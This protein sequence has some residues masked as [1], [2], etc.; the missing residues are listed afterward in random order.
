MHSHSA[1]LAASVRT[2]RSSSG[3][4][5][6]DAL[7]STRDIEDEL[8]DLSRAGAAGITGVAARRLRTDLTNEFVGPLNLSPGSHRNRHHWLLSSM[9]FQWT[10]ISLIVFNGITLGLEANNPE[11][12]DTW[13]VCDHFFT[14]AFFVEFVV[15]ASLL[16]RGYF[17]DVGNIMDCCLVAASAADVW[18]LTPL[19]TKSELETFSVLRILRILRLVR[20]FRIFTLVRRFVLI[21]RTLFDALLTT[22]W[23]GTIAAVWLYVIAIFTTTWI[24]HVDPNVYPGY[25]TDITEID[26]SEI[27][28]NFNPYTSFG[29]VSR[30]MFTLFNIA[31]GAEWAEVVRPVYEKQPVMAVVLVIFVILVV[32]GVLNIIIA[33]IVDTVMQNRMHLERLSE[34]RDMRK[35]FK[36]LEAVKALF[37]QADTDGDGKVDL[38]ELEA[39]LNCPEVKIL[40]GN[41]NVPDGLSAFELL[42]MLDDTGDGELEL[43]EIARGFYRLVNSDTFQ[44]TCLIHMGINRL[45]ASARR[46]MQAIETTQGMLSR[47]EGAISAFHE[48][49][50]QFVA[51]KIPVGGSTTACCAGDAELQAGPESNPRPAAR[52][53][54]SSFALG[55]VIIDRTGSKVGHEDSAGSRAAP[56]L[57]LERRIA[58]AMQKVQDLDRATARSLAACCSSV[59]VEELSSHMDVLTRELDEHI[60]RAADRILESVG[61]VRDEYDAALLAGDPLLQQ[62]RL[63]QPQPHPHSSCRPWTYPL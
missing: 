57:D 33:M 58:D 17:E 38:E 9:C 36:R 20:V 37:C 15:K 42:C 29:G 2:A 26:Q 22:V 32:Y 30:S 62:R 60:R 56:A 41:V 5:A 21:L 6:Q 35:K 43:N 47:L 55:D 28:Q 18:I 40:L 51:R 54:W 13:S 46:E 31:L 27:M 48:D 24:G 34:V 23:V 8:S 3:S 7:W 44:K 59:V 63:K 12:T 49:F 53:D 52:S 10:I 45:T 4:S 16:R 39:I 19:G 25:A 61:A 1:A 11:L 14:A 50:K